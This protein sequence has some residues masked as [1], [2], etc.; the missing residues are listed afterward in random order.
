MPGQAHEYCES[1]IDPQPLSPAE[2]RFHAAHGGEDKGFLFGEEDDVVGEP[3]KKPDKAKGKEKR[4]N[5]AVI[6]AREDIGLGDMGP[7][8]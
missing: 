7:S 3:P 2:K 5:S 4:K 1:S 8:T 6:R